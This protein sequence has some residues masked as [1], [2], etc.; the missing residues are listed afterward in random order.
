MVPLLDV[1]L[2]AHPTSAQPYGTPSWRLTHGVPFSYACAVSCLASTAAAIGSPRR[3]PYLAQCRCARTS[4]PS[5]TTTGGLA[6]QRCPWHACSSSNGACCGVLAIPRHLT[7][8]TLHHCLFDARL[9][10]CPSNAALGSSLHDIY[11]GPYL[12]DAC[13]IADTYLCTNFDAI[14]SV[15]AYLLSDVNSFLHLPSFIR[16]W[17]LVT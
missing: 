12:D 11:D 8:T 6:Q 16:Q 14:C 9:G 13:C 2:I 15:V 1:L 7:L 3:C 10:H 4:E 5:E 17:S